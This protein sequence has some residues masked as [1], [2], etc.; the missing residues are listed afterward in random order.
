MDD[1]P[2]LAC[3]SFFGPSLAAPIQTQTA[4]LLPHPCSLLFISAAAVCLLAS[5]AVPQLAQSLLL[6]LLALSRLM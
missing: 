5:L 4:L 1:R 2:V 6:P 3:K